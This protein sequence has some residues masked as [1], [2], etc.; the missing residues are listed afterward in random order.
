MNN[1]VNLV[2]GPTGRME[3]PNGCTL[4]WA[5][6]G[7]GGRTFTSDEIGCGVL[8]WDTSVVEEETLLTAMFAERS[9]KALLPPIPEPPPM[10]ESSWEPPP[11]AGLLFETP[12]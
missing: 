5:P 8:V 7:V 10:P 12:A 11:P 2:F 4:Y 1:P 3:L 6:N 9:L